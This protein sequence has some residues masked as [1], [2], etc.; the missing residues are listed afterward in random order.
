M[1]QGGVAYVVSHG[2]GASIW[3]ETGPHGDLL[4]LK[5]QLSQHAVFKPG[6]IH[7]LEV[8]TPLRDV[9]DRSSRVQRGSECGPPRLLLVVEQDLSG[10]FS[11]NLPS[12][13]QLLLPC[14]R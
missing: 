2:K 5:I 4:S 6:R 13:H 7:N 1:V 11:D 14:F 3:L 10:P 8:E 9:L 12:F